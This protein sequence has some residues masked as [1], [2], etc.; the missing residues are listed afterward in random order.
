M[1]L[2]ETYVDGFHYADEVK[3]LKYICLGETGLKVSRLGFGAGCFG[4]HYGDYKLEDAKLALHEALK[5][6]IN[7]I[8]TAPFYGEGRSEE[9][10]GKLLRDVPRSAYYLAT[11]VGRYSLDVSKAFDFSREAT[12]KSVNNS[13]K[14][15]GLTYVDVIQVHDV[16][17]APSVD[18]IINET[19]PALEEIVKAGKAKFIGVTGYPLSRLLEVVEKSKTKIH[20]VLSYCRLTLMDD[21][22]NDYLPK[23]KSRGLAVLHASP[24]ALGL[25]TNRG[26]WSWHPGNNLYKDLCGRAA[27]YCKENG[28]ELGNLSVA[29]TATQPG[30]DVHL[31]GMPNIEFVKTNLN[32]FING[33]SEK[34]K[35]IMNEIF[36]RYFKPSDKRNWEN[37]EVSQY[38]EAEK[39][40]KQRK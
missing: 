26:S 38:I 1:T 31:I 29:Y 21:A 2:P 14:K 36:N 13:L 12:I 4:N 8:D 6:G 18:I 35:K 10:L 30:V 22:L 19:L 25:L 40:L 11:K 24:G 34:E 3:K 39:A 27:Q 23:F 32:V 5:R 20:A 28:V 15:L 33:I 7:Y 16:E 9:T 17:F 37:I